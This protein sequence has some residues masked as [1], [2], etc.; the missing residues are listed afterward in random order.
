MSCNL[1]EIY[2]NFGQTVCGLNTTAIKDKRG[3]FGHPLAAMSYLWQRMLEW[4][5]QKKRG[6]SVTYCDIR[7]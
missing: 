1:V 7:T 6:P 4:A 5:V 3:D 2:R